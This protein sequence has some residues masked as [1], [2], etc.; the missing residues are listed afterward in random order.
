[1]LR[2]MDYQLKGNKKD[3]LLQFFDELWTEL[4]S[5]P[6]HLDSA[7]SKRAKHT[8]SILAQILPQILLQPNSLAEAVGVGV[9]P[10]EP[11]SL[12]PAQIVKWRPA[13]LM[14]EYLYRSMSQG[15]VQTD[16]VVEDFPSQ[17]VDEW[18]ADFGPEVAEQLAKTLGQEA[19][20]SLRVNRNPG[21]TKLLDVLKNEERIPVR[22]QISDFS[23][24]G[25][26]LA[27]YAPLLSTEM[28]EKGAFEI[29]DEGSQIMALFS[30][31]PDEFSHLL[32]ETPGSVRIPQELPKLPENISPWTVVDACAGAGGKSLALADLLKGK[33]RIY[34][35]DVSERK[36]QALRR[37]ATRAGVTNIQAVA[38]EEGNESSAINR[39]EKTANAVLVDAP[40]SGWGVLRRNPDIKWRQ[41]PDV[42]VRMPS[43]QFRLLSLYSSLVAPG[44]RLTYGVCTFRKA[45]TRDVVRAFLDAHPDFEAQQGGFVGPGPSDGF[46]MQSFLRKA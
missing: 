14:A 42:L 45:E 16:P 26:R 21:P 22:A 44:G 23:P 37:R 6:I 17:M 11:W 35:Y 2:T 25:I 10:G 46:F 31:F 20:L 39:F 33:G 8:K 32:Q 15:R 36:L 30:L 40:C 24:V 38:L 3:Q 13:H 19:P 43:I 41:T 27:G 29:Q 9:A 4:F 7:L 28:Y 12:T 5:S 34:S 18:K 1:M